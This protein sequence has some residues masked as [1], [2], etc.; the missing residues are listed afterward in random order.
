MYSFHNYLK[1]SHQGN[2]ML[3][4]KHILGFQLL[5]IIVQLNIIG[6]KLKLDF[7]DFDMYL[8]T[9]YKFPCNSNSLYIFNRLYSLTI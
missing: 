8:H 7:I 1:L 3:R 5:N 2:I 9:F 6:A 4:K